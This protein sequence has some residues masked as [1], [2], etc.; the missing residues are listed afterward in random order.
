MTV[1]ST[2][3]QLSVATMLGD[4][5]E[6]G[7]RAAAAQYAAAAIAETDAINRRVLGRV[8]PATVSVD[9]RLG[10][11]LA[12]VRLNGGVILAD[13]A[14]VGD[15]LVWI[16]RTLQDRSPIVSG[17]YRDAHTLFADAVEVEIG[18][19]IP[20]ASQYVFL[21]PVPYAHKIE[22]GK[23]KSGRDFVVQVPNRIYERAADDANARFGNVASIRFS[24][25]APLDGALLKYMPVRGPVSRAA[26]ALEREL[27]VPSI[28]VTLRSN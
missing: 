22:I 5:S 17:R 20:P 24:Y 8:P 13:W 4:V 12:S 18:K 3:E 7:Q 16:G 26:S 23:T 21:N 25:R 6:S 10:A 14:V 1:R 28:I 15:V 27:R 11:P 2:F 19:D 9:G